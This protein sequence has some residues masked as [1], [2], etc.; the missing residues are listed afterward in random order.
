M[1]NTTDEYV[2]F[3]SE[4]FLFTPL[5]TDYVEKGKKRIV[6]LA[7][8]IDIS[9]SY[10]AYWSWV[11][12]FFL[13][14]RR[15][16]CR[17]FTRI[18]RGLLNDRRV[19]IHNHDEVEDLIRPDLELILLALA[20]LRNAPITIMFHNTN[21]DAIPE[22]RRPLDIDRLVTPHPLYEEIPRGLGDGDISH[23]PF[24]LVHAGG[25]GGAVSPLSAES[26]P[27]PSLL[28][29]LRA[30][31]DAPEEPVA[32]RLLGGLY[33][34]RRA[35]FLEAHAMYNEAFLTFYKIIELYLGRVQSHVD[36]TCAADAL[37]AE[38]AAIRG[39]RPRTANVDT[40]FN[41][42][43]GRLAIERARDRFEKLVDQSGF[44]DIPGIETTV[45]D[46]RRLMRLPKRRNEIE[47]HAREDAWDQGE[48]GQIEL[49]VCQWFAM[50]L[51]RRDLGFSQE[52]QRAHLV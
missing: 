38:A 33:Y 39:G 25:E 52:W 27:I 2:S 15:Y 4:G 19:D 43:R 22:G 31:V 41:H 17:I 16:R 24:H 30:V 1:D 32:R 46:K 26:L 49:T 12:S 6:T 51:L 28:Q 35:L 50:Y 48:V 23:V 44:L 45:A 20:L 40:I 21:P 34:L 14:T 11:G 36:P 47:A 3:V 7:G 10:G 9:I 18:A 29:K 5:V 37:E 42:L 8:C 13:K